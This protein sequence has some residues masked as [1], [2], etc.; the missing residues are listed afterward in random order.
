M[1]RWWA[2]L[3]CMLS[4]TL[5]HAG[6]QQFTLDNG[7]RVIVQE[8]HRSPVVVSQLWYRVGSMDEFNGSTGLSHMLE[9]M[10]FKGTKTVP[11]G[12]FS[13]LIASVGGRENAFTNLDYTVYFEQLQKDRLGLA[14]RL[15]AD[16][17]HNLLLAEDSFRQENRVVQEERRMR[18]EDQP[19]AL[20]YENLMATTF[21]A[22]PYRRPV[23]GWMDD[24]RNLT[25]DDVRHWYQSWYAPNNATLVVVGDVQPDAVR[26]LA[27][28][29]FG[30]IASHPLPVRKPQEEPQQVGTKRIV[31]KAPAKVPYMMM[32]WH[33]P[34][35]RDYAHDWQPY[36]LQVLAGVLD[37]NS[38]A[39][40]GRVVV[41]E[42][43]IAS[44]A[45]ASYDLVGR[46]PGLFVI[47]ATPMQGKTMAE[48]E[49]ALQAQ[50]RSIAEQGVS[51]DELRR[52]KSQ[53]IAD[54]VYRRDSMFY[55]A[56]LLGEYVT[57]GLPV[58]AVAAQADRVSAVTAQQVQQVAKQY[59]VDDALTV[60]TLDPQPWDEHHERPAVDLHDLR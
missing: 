25:V 35:L 24:I 52:V 60:A 30:G 34:V 6:V 49:A 1:K 15:E 46:G 53:V 27:Q 58:E 51:A 18:T 45:S 14:F 21:E 56:M 12:Q 54:N 31:V 37:G 39:R 41:R 38:G 32:A 48:L 36:A 2:G 43:R 57:D 3:V 29:Y 59:L 9:H 20:V 33:V 55:Q 26:A 47:D 16:R 8:D 7:L 42:Q 4:V 13:R 22:N 44:E 40:L 28:Q 19:E 11:D 50:V 23:I 17:M 10:M 5:A